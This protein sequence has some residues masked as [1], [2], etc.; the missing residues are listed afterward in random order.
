MSNKG[1]GLP[2]YN[3]FLNGRFIPQTA[4]E[5]EQAQAFYRTIQQSRQ[6]RQAAQNRDR[7]LSHEEEALARKRT[8]QTKQIELRLTGRFNRELQ[9]YILNTPNPKVQ[10]WLESYFNAKSVNFT[11]K[12]STHFTFTPNF[13]FH[14]FP[15]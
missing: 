14:N 9:H 11:F 5:E 3:D 7:Q 8:W 4:Q 15:H 10:N 12:I 6:A 1:R 13:C 2:P